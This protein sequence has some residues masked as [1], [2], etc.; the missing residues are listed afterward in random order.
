MT[1]VVFV[2]GFASSP[3]QMHDVASRGG[4]YLGRAATGV[5]FRES[6]QQSERFAELIDGRDVITHSGGM[7][8]VHRA[9]EYGAQP[10][11]LTSI[12]VPVPEQV[13]FLLWRGAAIQTGI[14]DDVEPQLR[15]KI[16]GP[17]EIRKHFIGNFRYVAPLGHFDAIERAGDFT[18]QGIP[19]T[20]GLMGRDGMFDYSTA[21]VAGSIQHAREAGAKVLEL[22]GAHCRFTHQTAGMLNELESA[23]D[24]IT[25]VKPEYISIRGFARQAY[26]RHHGQSEPTL[27]AA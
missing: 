4:A 1:E 20:V 22:E 12:A 17:S 27:T 15:Q 8:A 9:V 2:G 10:N 13:R 7:Y 16:E 18:E 3:E 21:S 11:R 14:T 6:L 19:T 25:S 5:C 26:A 24:F 23:P